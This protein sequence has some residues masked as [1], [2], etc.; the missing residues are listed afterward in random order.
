M[1]NQRSVGNDASAAAP[2]HIV[3][4]GASAGGLESL[5]RFFSRLPPDTG[6]A[7]VVLQH[8]SPDFKSLMDELLGRRTSMAIRQAEHEAVVE[9]NVL[10]LLPPMKEMIMMSR[11]GTPAPKNLGLNDTAESC[12]TPRGL[13][14]RA[15]GGARYPISVPPF[16]LR[17]MPVTLS[18]LQ[19]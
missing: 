10:Y 7:F 2:F 15:T 3:A 4:I 1:L 5:E 18:A 19:R 12:A 8:L 17:A 6:M 16:T 13:N 11:P 14:A 9:P